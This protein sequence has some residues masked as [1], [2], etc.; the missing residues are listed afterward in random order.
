[1]HLVCPC[2]G[3]KNWFPT[4]ARRRHAGR[5]HGA[6]GRR[7]GAAVDRGAAGFAAG[8]ELPVLVDFWAEWCGPFASLGS[9]QFA[10][11][12]SPAPDVRFVKVDS[13]EAPGR[14]HSTGSGIPTLVLAFTGSARSP[15][16]RAAP[17]GEIVAWVGSHVAVLR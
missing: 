17:A 13:D 5:C 7:A 9:C 14:A 6:D 15:P 3:A 4:P 2:G 1:M 16:L 8:T 12:G 11:A 10:A